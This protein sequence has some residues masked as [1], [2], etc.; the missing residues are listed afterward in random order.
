M[1]KRSVKVFTI[2]A[3]CV[4]IFVLLAILS[5]YCLFRSSFS[6]VRNNQIDSQNQT[7]YLS[8]G[9]LEVEFQPC[10]SD[11]TDRTGAIR[12]YA[13]VYPDEIYAGDSIYVV[14][15]AKNLSDAPVEYAAYILHYSLL[16][17]DCDG[18]ECQQRFK[19][20][21]DNV[22]SYYDD[23]K[24]NKLIPILTPTRMVAVGIPF[25]IEAHSAVA[26][27]K[28]R[29]EIPY[30]NQWRSP[31]WRRT[32]QTLD[33]QG[34]TVNLLL[35]IREYDELALIP[36]KIKPRPDHEMRLLDKWHTEMSKQE[37]FLF[38]P[39]DLEWEPSA[40]K[41]IS[42]ISIHGNSFF[43]SRVPIAYFNG[44]DGFYKPSSSNAP[45][46]IQDWRDLESS[47]VPS[48]MRDEIRM[49]RLLLEYYDA[50]GE[51]QD[52]K[53]EEIKSWLESLPAVQS[54]IL[55]RYY[56]APKDSPLYESAQKIKPVIEKFSY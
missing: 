3:L 49:T 51:K 26:V 10:K 2:I 6:K 19:A 43:P 33:P 48:T 38:V 9:I 15:K 53:L 17:A 27:D 56:D 5:F 37:D 7:D 36:I 41:K 34:T 42:F 11:R 20:Y 54:S 21:Q 40:D 24:K 47:L 32:L 29:F 8:K 46:T 4:L 25:K 52:K 45:K 1:K 50:S 39:E 28:R 35:F 55:V 12:H 16:I 30:L 31:Y 14:I 44:R 13:E 22:K 18:V 23:I